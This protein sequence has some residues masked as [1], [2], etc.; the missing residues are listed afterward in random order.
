MKLTPDRPPTTPEALAVLRAFEDCSLP[1]ADWNHQAHCVV[2]LFYIENEP[3]ASAIERLS[4]AICQY[5]DA[6]ES[7]RSDGYHATLTT[8]FMARLDDFLNRRGRPEIN[9]VLLAALWADPISKLDYA[10]TRYT[11]ETLWS[12]EA[13]R[14]FVLPDRR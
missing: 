4:S 7:G 5:H 8:L 3:L 10:L 1:L 11:P 14:R 2:G 9:D 12:G 6:N 13:R